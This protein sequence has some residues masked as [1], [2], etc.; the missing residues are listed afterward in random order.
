V[1]QS[2]VPFFAKCKDYPHKIGNML[3][4][5]ADVCTEYLAVSSIAF[6]QWYFHEGFPFE[7]FISATSRFLQTMWLSAPETHYSASGDF[8]NTTNGLFRRI[9]IVG[10]MPLVTGSFS[11]PSFSA[12]PSGAT[13]AEPVLRPSASPPVEELI[14]V[15]SQA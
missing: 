10:T 6:P 3:P 14:F 9:P 1:P 15:L 4:D 13:K 7:E 11:A 8:R 5:S 2:L 12:D